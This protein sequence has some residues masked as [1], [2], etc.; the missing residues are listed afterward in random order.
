MGVSLKVYFILRQFSCAFCFLPA[1][2]RTA[3][4]GLALL[5]L[6][7]L[8]LRPKISRTNRQRAGTSEVKS[9]IRL[10]FFKLSMSV[11]F[12]L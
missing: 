4:F 8:Y 12:G 5:P 1:V 10:P 7:P 2:S 3:F 6:F 9:Q 11:V